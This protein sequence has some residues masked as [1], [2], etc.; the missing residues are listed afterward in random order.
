MWWCPN[1]QCEVDDSEVTFSETHDERCGG[2]GYRVVET[3]V[4][5]GVQSDGAY[6]DCENTK[7]SE[8]DGTCELCGLRKSSRR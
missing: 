7:S 3:P 4:Q 6:C 2:C 5:Q 8:F 1:C